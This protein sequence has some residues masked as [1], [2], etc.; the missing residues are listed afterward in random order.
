MRVLWKR[1]GWGFLVAAGVG[2][3]VAGPAATPSRLPVPVDISSPE[4]QALM[5]SSRPK[6]GV[7]DVRTGEITALYAGFVTLPPMPE[8]PVGPPW[9]TRQAAS[10]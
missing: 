2:L 7:I 10:G 1:L 5:H 6:T 3:V 9:F 4:G 8:E